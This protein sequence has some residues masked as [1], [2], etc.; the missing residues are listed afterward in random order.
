MKYIITEGRLTQ[1]IFNYLDSLDWYDWDIG[2]DEFNIAEG[3]YGRDLIRFRIQY[4]LTVYD[5][6]FEVIYID[7]GLITKLSKLFSI[8]DLI[9]IKTIIQWFNKRY[10]KNLTIDNFEWMD[11]D[12]D[13]DDN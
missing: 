11:T 3:E 2:D 5:H 7:E 1:I 10:G 12:Y 8:P 6:S 4:S 9:S 13:D